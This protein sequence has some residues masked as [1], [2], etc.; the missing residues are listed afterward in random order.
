MVNQRKSKE[1][2]IAGN[3]IKVIFLLPAITIHQF[4]GYITGFTDGYILCIDLPF[5]CNSTP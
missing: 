3:S 4:A 5:L 2:G 1:T